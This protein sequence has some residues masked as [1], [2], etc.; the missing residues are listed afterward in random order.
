MINTSGITYQKT[1]TWVKYSLRTLSC[2]SKIP[3]IASPDAMNS[4]DRYT[5]H[6]AIIPHYTNPDDKQAFLRQVFDDSAEHYE[7][8]ARWGFFG[9]GDW[10]RRQALQRAG[11]VPGMRAVDVAA[12]TGITARAMA[13]LLGGPE[14]LV[15]IEPSA[16]MLAESAKQLAAHHLQGSAEAIPLPDGEYDFLSMGFALRHVDNL[17]IAFRE[18]YRVLKPGGRLLIM[19]ITKPDSRL[20]NTLVKFYFRDFMPRFT[21]LITGSAKAEY[22]MRYYW[23][24]VDLMI[25]PSQVLE[26]LTH[27]GFQQPH[28]HV[29]ARI[30]S[31][32]T[33]VK[34]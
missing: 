2:P 17:E 14:H 7:R 13:S 18:F 11:L 1:S 16:A 27:A 8:V 24:T 32:Y 26:A 30:F 19:D 15:C 10:Y 4:N 3:S 29:E 25:P 31:E 9:T 21:R 33:A 28:R 6:P 22:L 34:P 12:G 5:P 23:D 20:G